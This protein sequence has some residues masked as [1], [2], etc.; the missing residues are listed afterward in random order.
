MGDMN[1]IHPIP[2]RQYQAS[3]MPYHYLL[4][5]LLAFTTPAAAQNFEIGLR[6]GR[7]QALQDNIPNPYGRGIHAPIAS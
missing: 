1:Q 7:L 5:L 2:I 4:L 6:L 3:P